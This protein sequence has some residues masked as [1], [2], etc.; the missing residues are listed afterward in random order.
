MHVDKLLSSRRRKVSLAV[1]VAHA[2]NVLRGLYAAAYGLE[3]VS[4]SVVMRSPATALV[5][6]AMGRKR[7]RA[8]SSGA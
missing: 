8:L 1:H 7:P 6:R 2:D 3:A 5:T 4:S